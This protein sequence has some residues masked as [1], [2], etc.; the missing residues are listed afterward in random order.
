MAEFGE[1]FGEDGGDGAGG[2]LEFGGDLV[3]L[4]G[5]HAEEE[6]LLFAIGEEVEEA[7]EVAEVLHGGRG[8]GFEIGEGDD[9][10]RASVVF[11][12]LVADDGEGPGAGVLDDDADG[13]IAVVF[14]EGFVDEVF[15]EGDVRGEGGGVAQKGRTPGLVEFGDGG[16]GVVMSHAQGVNE[17]V[18]RRAGFV[19]GWKTSISPRRRDCKERKKQEGWGM[20]AGLRLWPRHSGAPSILTRR[21]AAGPPHKKKLKT[22][23]VISHPP[24]P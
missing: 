9:A 6:D 20:K 14:E 19:Y 12:K 11:V 18:S 15:G 22:G 5:V 4:E 7:A 2:D 21:R 16:G 17:N 8:D 13:E 23:E 10:A 24:L 3:V 1:R